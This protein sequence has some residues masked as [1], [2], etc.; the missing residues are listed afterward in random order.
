VS[1]EFLARRQRRDDEPI[2]NAEHGLPVS[3]SSGIT[4][5]YWPP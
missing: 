4:K 3:S 2:E 5:T 1:L